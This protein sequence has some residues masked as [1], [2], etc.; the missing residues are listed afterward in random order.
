MQLPLMD[1]FSG[2][3]QHR[4]TRTLRGQ[5]FTGFVCVRV[6]VRV[7]LRGRRKRNPEEWLSVGQSE[8]SGCLAAWLD[9]LLLLLLLLAS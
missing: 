9:F 7:S 3:Q 5:Q 1:F 8:R 4:R 2:E 6:C